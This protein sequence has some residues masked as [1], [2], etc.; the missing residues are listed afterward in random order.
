MFDENEILICLDCVKDIRYKLLIEQEN[1]RG[2]CTCCEKNS[3]VIDVDS[4]EFLQ[5]TKALIRYHFSEW[6]Y[7]KHYGGDGYETLFHENDNIFL[8]KANFKN[9]EVYDELLSRIYSI[10]VYE[11]YDKGVSI[12]AGY[13]EGRQNPLLISIKKDLDF[14]II[15]IERKL[16]EENYFNF[17]EEII[18]I[19]K[20]Y[21]QNC[22]R[23]V[24]KGQAFFRARIGFEDKKRSILGGFEGEMVFVP[25]SHSKIGAPPPS[26]AGFGRINR[27]GVSYLYCAS[28]KYTAISEIR[29]HPGDVVSIGKFLLN[30]DCLIFDL[31]ESQFLNFYNSDEK[32]DAFKQ[33]NT[34]TELLQK[35]IP[36]S[37]RQAY[38]I[39]QL[40][41]D[42]IRKLDFE[43]ILFPS[44][45]G[46]GHNL[47]MFNPKNM[48]YTYED[49]EVAEVSE[50][51]YEVLCRKN[52]VSIHC[53]NWTDE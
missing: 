18:K 17:E 8:N 33:L 41:A 36:P 22:S 52:L 4:Y 23:T 50:V 10:E 2:Q 25:Y 11:E 37:E 40:I 46:Q 26:L 35:V 24:N 45:V 7:N 44:S 34:I 32:L 43:G 48:N 29:P 21:V 31:T 3:Y 42:C 39:T 49:A 12:F 19:L 20:K 5:M 28:D 14:S 13:Y 16:K 27:A 51:K 47:V 38:N 53:Q 15:E 6:D 1:K 9:K 30:K